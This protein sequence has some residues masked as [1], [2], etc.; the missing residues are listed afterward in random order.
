[1]KKYFTKEVQIALVAIV[2][3]VVLFFGLKFLKGLSLVA[4]SNVYPVT[5]HDISGL[6]ASSPV[7][8]NG[9]KVGAVKG[10]DY[11]YQGTGAIV[12]HVE[13]DPQMRVPRGSS[14][15][16][17]SDFMGNVKMNLILGDNP[18]DLLENGDTI[19]GGQ[20]S[21]MMAKAEEMMPA[22]Q[23]M[24]PK[25]DSILM[26]LNLLLA[27]PAL[28]NSLHNVEHITANLEITTRGVNRLMDNLNGSVPGMMQRADRILANT[29]DFTDKL[30]KVEVSA[31]MA[32]VDNTLAQVEQLTTRLNSK[33]ST[34]GLLMTDP[35]LYINLTNTMRNADSLLYDLRQHPK[36]YGTFSLFTNKLQIQRIDVI[37]LR[38]RPVRKTAH[39]N[40]VLTVAVPHLRSKIL[41]TCPLIIGRLITLHHFFIGRST[42]QQHDQYTSRKHGKQ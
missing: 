34:I 12:A 23:Q 4:N 14:A 16:I 7:Y 40:M 27:D 31:T 36:R 29:E 21:G 13:L 24:L 26:S 8:A 17:A 20:S 3:I 15:E 11:D 33:E 25:L 22:I 28:T 18:A 19:R 9:Y 32:K 39:K 6:S 10:I 35:Q 2:G 1:M 41:Y 30:S 42:K 5:F 38:I 37:R